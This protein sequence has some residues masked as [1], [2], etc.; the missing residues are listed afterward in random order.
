MLDD[1]KSWEADKPEGAPNLLV[2]STGEVERNREQG[3]TSPVVLDSGFNV[4]RAFGASGTPSAVLV[5][6]A[7]F[8]NPAA[9]G[10]TDAAGAILQVSRVEMGL[11]AAIGAITF[12]G[13]VIAFLKLNGN[14][15]G[16]PILL[17]GRHVINLVTLAAILSL[18]AYFTQDQ[19][20]WVFWSRRC[21]SRCRASAGRCRGHGLQA[22]WRV[23][24]P[25]AVRPRGAAA[26]SEWEPWFPRGGAPVSAAPH[27]RVV[28]DYTDVAV[29]VR[30]GLSLRNRYQ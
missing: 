18:I 10:I 7:A 11:G 12:S 24:R 27:L 2:V 15:S 20:P 25:L 6:A 13:S 16:S 19:A 29:V 26:P 5:G 30:S 3:F 17:P 1:L 22:A 9:F 23:R 4:G 8:L 28:E 21:S 14:M